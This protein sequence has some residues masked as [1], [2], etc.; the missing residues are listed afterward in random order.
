MDLDTVQFQGSIFYVTQKPHGLSPGF[1]GLVEIAGIEHARP[2]NPKL[3][4]SPLEDS[5]HNTANSQCPA[6]LQ[7]SRLLSEIRGPSAALCR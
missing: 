5:G 1:L 3:N 4:N 7:K 2:D 6:T